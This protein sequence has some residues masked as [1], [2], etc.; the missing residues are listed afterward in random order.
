MQ[1]TSWAS[2]SSPS[3]QHHS[4]HS[5]IWTG[6]RD[7]WS[8]PWN[9]CH[10]Q[11]RRSRS[12]FRPWSVTV[13]RL[14]DCSNRTHR[15]VT[16]ICDRKEMGAELPKGGALVLLHHVNVIQMRQ[17]LERVHR[18]QD[19][20][21]VGLSGCLTLSARW[22]PGTQCSLD[23]KK[24]K[25]ATKVSG[26]QVLTYISLRPYRQERL[27]RTPGSWRYA[28][29]VMSS[30]PEGGASVSLGYMLPRLATTW[31]QFLQSY[32]V[33]ISD[34]NQSQRT[35]TSSRSYWPNQAIWQMIGRHLL[36]PW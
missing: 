14:Y 24:K 34:G 9:C 2:S 13:Y 31:N 17:S 15:P 32:Y 4:H 19:V 36:L 12:N 7:H 8:A 26:R 6:S 21:G 30:T 25:I 5:P 23:R 1:D 29:F 28:S 22:K 33:L 27:C 16:G 18:N 10:Q 3:Y 11:G 35:S 20:P